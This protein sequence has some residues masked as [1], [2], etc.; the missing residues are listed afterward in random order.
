MLFFAGNH[1]YEICRDIAKKIKE[2]GYDGIIYSSYYS[3][4]R[5]GAMPFETVYGISVRMFPSYKEHAKSQ[6]I[7]NIA[8]FGKPIAEKIVSV[9][10]INRL[11]LN[12]VI[13]DYHF[14]PVEFE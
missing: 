14:G 6:I 2:A 11:I 4:L 10:C 1:S 12:K 7:Q 9:K 5:T 13:Y 8:L 3:S